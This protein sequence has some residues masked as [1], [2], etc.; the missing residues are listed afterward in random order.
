[1]HDCAAMPPRGVLSLLPVPIAPTARTTARGRGRERRTTSSTCTR[2]IVATN[3]E[4][5]RRLEEK[6]KAKTEKREK[7]RTHVAIEASRQLG[8]H[9]SNMAQNV[10]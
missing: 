2:K 3:T 9:A 6:E 7:R 1:M 8:T 10:K 4:E 5:M